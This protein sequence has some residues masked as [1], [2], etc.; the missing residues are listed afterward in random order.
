MSQRKENYAN[1]PYVLSALNVM[2]DESYL[3][4]WGTSALRV[5]VIIFS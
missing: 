2:I 3:E 5:R 4:N 1:F